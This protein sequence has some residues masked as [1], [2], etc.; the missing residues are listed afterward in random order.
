MTSSTVASEKEL[1]ILPKSVDQKASSTTT[2]TLSTYELA[3]LVKY[4]HLRGPSRMMGGRK[5]A[6]LF[7]P[8]LLKSKSN[9]SYVELWCMWTGHLCKW[10]MC[11]SLAPSTQTFLELNGT[12]IAVDCQSGQLEGMIFLQTF[13][14]SSSALN[15]PLNFSGVYSDS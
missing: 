4:G 9:D 10:S 14:F 6:T 15:I 5:E 11:A 2:W 12:K 3:R 7:T 1:L 8:Y 13:A